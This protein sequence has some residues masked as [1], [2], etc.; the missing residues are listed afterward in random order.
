MKNTPRLSQRS[1]ERMRARSLPIPRSV[2]TVAESVRRRVWRKIC[3]MR[4]EILEFLL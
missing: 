1:G 2:L 3:V 4:V